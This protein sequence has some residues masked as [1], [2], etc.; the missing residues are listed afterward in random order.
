MSQR[1]SSIRVLGERVSACALWAVLASLSG[2]DAGNTTDTP[3]GA[4]AIVTGQETD[5]WTQTPVPQSVLAELVGTMR[6]SLGTVPAPAT[7]VSLGSGSPAESPAS[8]EITGF[9]ADNNAVIAGT[10]VPLSID[11]FA[12]AA[13]SVFVGRTGGFSRGPGALV[14]EYRHPLLEV[15]SHAFVIIAGGDVPNAA[16]ASVDV[17]DMAN[18]VVAPKQAWLPRVPKSWA[19]AGAN[20]LVIDETGAIWLDVTTGDTAAVTGPSGFNFADIVGGQTLV[21]ASDTRYIVGATRATGDPS[22]S[23]L[24]VASDGTLRALTLSSARLGAAAAVVDGQLVVTGGSASGAGVEALNADETTFVA[25]AY[26]P[27]ATQGAALTELTTTTA[28]VVGGVDPATSTQGGLRTID[29]TCT[30]SCAASPLAN[31]DFSYSQAQAFQLGNRNVMVTG[32]SADGETHAF[33]LS[34]TVGYELTEQP[35]R[36]PRTG[37]SSFLM[38][39]GQVGL[40]AGDAL[41]DGTPASSVE[42]FFPVQ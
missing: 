32:E 24:R 7:A 41:A 22:A 28:V 37:A 27:D 15:I 11:T 39:N 8:F 35:L 13:P 18:W 10:S 36:T 30:D 38:P 5:T 21:G 29:L 20:L 19:V 25:L 31:A 40:V 12:G 33:T 6:T 1:I 3:D 17:Y 42:L 23:V 4:L 14:F 2:C 26:P 34:K 9:D 16:Q